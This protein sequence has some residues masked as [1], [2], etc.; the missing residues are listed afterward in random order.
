M[1][2][3]SN[4]CNAYYRS[5]AGTVGSNPTHVINA[6]LYLRCPVWVETL[7]QVDPPSKEL[8]QVSINK[9]PKPRK[10]DSLDSTGLSCHTR[11]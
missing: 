4:S 3:P 10:G 2:A 1:V 8:Y 7:L 9:I 6:Y 11:I 5:K